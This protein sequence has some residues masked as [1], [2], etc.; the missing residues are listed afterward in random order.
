MKDIVQRYWSK[1]EKVE[2]CSPGLH[3]HKGAPGAI[4]HLEGCD[5]LTC[6]WRISGWN[7]WAGNNAPQRDLWPL[8]GPAMLG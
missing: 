1:V 5:Q 4:V 3:V 8:R 6:L 2:D 7:V